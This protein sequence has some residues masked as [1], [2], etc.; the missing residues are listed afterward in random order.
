MGI[1]RPRMEMAEMHAYDRGLDAGYAFVL[2]GGSAEN[3][4][5]PGTPEHAQWA[6]GFADGE[7]DAEILEAQ[8]E[9]EEIDR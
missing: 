3:S 8:R 9:E 6:Q 5:M 1:G 7:H 2:E 4:E